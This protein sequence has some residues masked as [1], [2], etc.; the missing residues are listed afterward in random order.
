MVLH[1]KMYYSC[2][3]CLALTNNKIKL[4]IKTLEIL[5]DIIYIGDN[6]Q[7]TTFPIYNVNFN[8]SKPL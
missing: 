1:R 5:F 7:P 2:C 8:T 4:F 6:I 3:L